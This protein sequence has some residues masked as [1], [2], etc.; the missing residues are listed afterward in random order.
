M[1]TFPYLDNITIAGH[2]QME[3][4]AN[5]QKFLDILLRHNLTLNESKSVKSVPSVN[6]LGYW[7]GK[8]LIKLDPE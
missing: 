1:D 2:D 8:G 6:I 7:V 4:D 3:H 5:L